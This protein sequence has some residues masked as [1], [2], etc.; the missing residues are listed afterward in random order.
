M[1]SS[2]SEAQRS[3]ALGIYTIRICF[4]FAVSYWHKIALQKQKDRRAPVF[5][6]VNSSR[7]TQSRRIAAI[8]YI[9]S[10]M[11]P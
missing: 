4:G 6:F 5:L 1:K 3:H 7:M 11:S 9:N 2:P 8:G 10:V